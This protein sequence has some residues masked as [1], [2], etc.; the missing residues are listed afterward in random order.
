MH[1]KIRTFNLNEY[2]YLWVFFFVFF[3]YV[4]FVL[5]SI[6][7]KAKNVRRRQEKKKNT[8]THTL[9]NIKRYQHSTFGEGRVPLPCLRAVLCRNQ[10]DWKLFMH[11][12]HFL[13]LFYMMVIKVISEFHNAF[14][15]TTMYTFTKSC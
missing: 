4:F 15:C 2:K 6:C 7:N 12:A 5:S 10:T 1:N 13:L 8:H 14:K 3:V 11:C 9:W